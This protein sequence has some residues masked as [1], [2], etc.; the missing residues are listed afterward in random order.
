[1]MKLWNDVDYDDDYH[2]HGDD[3]E[4]EICDKIEPFLELVSGSVETGPFWPRS[5]CIVSKEG[6]IFFSILWILLFQ[7]DDFVLVV[8]NL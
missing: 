7:K 4:I 2:G 5:Q 3:E 1:M 8:V 6:N